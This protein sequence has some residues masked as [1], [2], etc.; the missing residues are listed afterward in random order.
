MEYVVMSNFP[1]SYETER[2]DISVQV[3]VNGVP[4]DSSVF[5]AAPKNEDEK[6]SL[7]FSVYQYVSKVLIDG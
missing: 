5:T 3:L 4:K 1:V 7:A 2:I 6:V